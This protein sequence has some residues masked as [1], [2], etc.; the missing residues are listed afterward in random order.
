MTIDG[1]QRMCLENKE[2]SLN[3]LT[4]IYLDINLS[5]RL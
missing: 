1:P 4:S 2:I 3:S 5:R